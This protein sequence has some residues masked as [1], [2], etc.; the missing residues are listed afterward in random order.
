MSKNPTF[1]KS[2]PALAVVCFLL[3]N[4]SFET[5]SQEVDQAGLGLFSIPRPAPSVGIPGIPGSTTMPGKGFCSDVSGFTAQSRD[6]DTGQAGL[7]SQR[8]CQS[9]TKVDLYF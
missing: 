2:S 4:L 5:G 3:G 1:P 6:R 8:N 7:K 9:E